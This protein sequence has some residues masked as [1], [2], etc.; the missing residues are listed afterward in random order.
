M[1]CGKF[2]FD[3]MLLFRTMIW[4]ILK[5]AFCFRWENNTLHKLSLH[6]KK[7][8]DMAVTDI[9][10]SWL[11][12]LWRQ[13]TQ[14]KKSCSLSFLFCCHCC[15]AS[16]GVVPIPKQQLLSLLFKLKLLMARAAIDT[17]RL[18][19]LLLDLPY[20]TGIKW[21]LSFGGFRNPLAFHGKTWKFIP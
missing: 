13:H 4:S 8:I 10:S 21:A 11:Y 18:L 19:G 3:P 16:C 9:R 1:H 7:D 20:I 14:K 2:H 12:W 6:F 17:I 5:V 15:G